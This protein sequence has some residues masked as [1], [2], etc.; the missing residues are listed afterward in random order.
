MQTTMA[1]IWLAVFVVMVVIEIATLG[2]TTI[3]FAGGALVAL[4]ISLFNPP[5]A[6]QIAVFIVVSVVLLIF[7]RP[8][9]AKHFNKKM[10]ATNVDSVPGEIGIVSVNIDNIAA[11]GTVM[12]KGMEW[13]A[14]T[15]SDD[16]KIEK[17]AKVKVLRVEG[18]KVIVEPTAE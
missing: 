5:V 2:L 18:V 11:T 6:V 4:I 13:T 14:R 12:I 8:I 1:F 3:W 16:L 7:T 10:V 9:A 15:E 17:G